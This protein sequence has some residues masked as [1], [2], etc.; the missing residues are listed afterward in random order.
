[1]TDCP[2]TFNLCCLWH[3]LSSPPHKFFSPFAF[4]V[5]VLGNCKRQYQLAD[6]EGTELIW[7]TM[8]SLS[9]DHP[10]Q[11]QLAMCPTALLTLFWL[12]L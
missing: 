1:M 5:M 12:L 8:V 7:G 11:G 6:D 4:L 10:Q 3:V 9:H 2:A